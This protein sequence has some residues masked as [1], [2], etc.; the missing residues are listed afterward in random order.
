MGLVAWFWVMLFVSGCM[1]CTVHLCVGREP[2]NAVPKKKSKYGEPVDEANGVVDLESP[3]SKRDP[4][5]EEEE[6]IKDE[7]E[8]EQRQKSFITLM[9]TATKDNKI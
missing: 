3:E 8:R 5:K 1:L 2:L 9:Q 6:R 4:A 7:R